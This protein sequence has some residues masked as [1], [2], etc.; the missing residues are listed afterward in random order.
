MYIWVA[1]AAP[2]HLITQLFD[3]VSY[4]DISEEQVS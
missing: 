2:Q 4:E 1:K 3:V